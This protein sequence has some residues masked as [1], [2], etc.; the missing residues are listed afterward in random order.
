M[1]SQKQKILAGA[2]DATSEEIS[3]AESPM[4]EVIVQ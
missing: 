2:S 3:R 1:F 4:A